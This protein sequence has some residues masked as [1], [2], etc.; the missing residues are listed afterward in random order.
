MKTD[1]LTLRVACHQ[2]AGKNNTWTHG[3]ADT[4][5]CRDPKACLIPTHPIWE[6]DWLTSPGDRVHSNGLSDSVGRVWLSQWRVEVF[7]WK[8]GMCSGG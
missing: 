7:G 1:G 8:V 3:Q 6:W 5:T 2:R 4:H